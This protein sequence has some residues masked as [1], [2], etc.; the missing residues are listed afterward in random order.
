MEIIYAAGKECRKTRLKKIVTDF[1]K[2]LQ[3]Q[4][5]LKERFKKDIPIIIHDYEYS[6]EY[7]NAT[8]KC[9][10]NGEAD[11]FFKWYNEEMR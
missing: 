9:N 1:A 3:E 2:E 8:R 7:L 5:C 11:D 6:K 10:V 4:G